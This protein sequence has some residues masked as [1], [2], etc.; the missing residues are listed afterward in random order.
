[1]ESKKKATVGL[2]LTVIMVLSVIATAISIV[3]SSPET[4][5]KVQALPKLQVSPGMMP[6]ENVGNET[7]SYDVPIMHVNLTADSANDIQI[8]VTGVTIQQVGN[9]PK[10]NLTNITVYLDEGTIGKFEPSAD[11]LL[12]F[13]NTAI[14]NATNPIN[15]SIALNLTEL[16][17]NPGDTKSIFVCVNYTSFPLSQ[18]LYFQ[19]KLW[20]VSSQD[21]IGGAVDV[22]L[23]PEPIVS[24]QIFATGTLKVEKGAFTAPNY[25][26][27]G[28]NETVVIMQVN[29]SAT[30][31]KSTL[32]SITL[33]WTGSNTSDVES[34]CLYNDTNKNGTLDANDACVTEWASFT[35]DEITLNFTSG[36]TVPVNDNVS[37]LIVVNTTKL[38]WSNDSLRVNIIDVDAVGDSSGKI[39]AI[40]QDTPLPIASDEIKGTAKVRVELGENQPIYKWIP[41]GDQ[42]N[43]E[44]VQLK[45]TAI[46]GKVNI[47]SLKLQMNKDNREIDGTTVSFNSDV[48]NATYP[49]V[50]MDVDGNGEIN[51]SDI[52]LN[53]TAGNL[54][55]DPSINPYGFV[56]VSLKPKNLT[57]GSET[58]TPEGEE[59]K[60]IIIAVNTSTN[61]DNQKIEI[62]I[63]WTGTEYNYTCYDVVTGQEGLH[64]D[65]QFTSNY[66][67]TTD[68]VDKDSVLIDIGPN[69]PSGAVDAGEGTFVGV[70]QLN[71]TNNMTGLKPSLELRGITVAANG[72]ANETIAISAL[73]L[74][75][76]KDMD[77]KYSAGDDVLLEPILSQP[78]KENDGNATITLTTPLEISAGATKTL[79]FFVNT[80]SN[81]ELTENL[82]FYIWNPSICFNITAMDGQVSVVN[83]TE[84]ALVGESLTAS[85]TVEAIFTGKPE[86]YNISSEANSTLIPLMQ[87][88]FSVGPTEPVN[89]TSITLNYTGSANNYSISK[90]IIVNDTDGDAQW[91]FETEAKLNEI[92]NPFVGNNN[93]TKLSF[94][95]NLTV[96]NVTGYGY[97]LVLVNINASAIDIGQ[98]VSVMISNP[99]VDYDASGVISGHGINDSRT[100]PIK[101][102]AL[103][104]TWTGKLSVTTIDIAN[105]TL[106]KGTYYEKELMKLQFSASDESINISSIRIQAN[107]SFNETKNITNVAAKVDGALRS[108]KVNF[109][110][111]DGYVVL[112][113]DPE[114]KIP[115]EKTRNVS[116][117]ADISGELSVGSEIVLRIE[118]PAR[119]IEAKGAV[120]KVKV[121][122]ET[123]TPL[124]SPQNVTITGSISVARGANTT[125]KGS[126]VAK[127]DS[128][129]EIL[130]LNFSAKY[131][132]VNITA[133]NLTWEGTFNCSP[134]NIT[135]GVVNDTD[136][137]GKIDSEEPVLNSTATFNTTTKVAS[138][139]L[140]P[141]NLT[142]PANGSAYMVIYLN[143]SGNFSP[144]ATLKVSLLN[145][146]ENCTAVGNVSGKPV[147]VEGV[148]IESETLTG[149]G[150]VVVQDTGKVGAKDILAGKNDSIVVWQFNITAELEN[151]TIES[152]TL[153]ENGTA[154]P[155]DFESVYL[156]NDTD[157]NGSWNKTT[158]P[159]ITDEQVPTTDNG[160]VTLTLTTPM[161]LNKSETVCYLVVVNT[162][163][164]FTDGETLAFNI[165]NATVEAKGEV[166][167]ISVYNN[168]TT[169][170]SNVTRGYGSI[171]LYAGDTQ[172]DIVQSKTG[173]VSVMELNFSAIRGAIDIMNITVRWIGNASTSKLSHISIWKDAD[174]D[175]NFSESDT[176]INIMPFDDEENIT[177]ETNTGGGS[178]R[179]LTVDGAT[180]NVY[181]V[182]RITDGLT[183]GKTLGF[184]V[185]QTLGVGYNAT[186]NKTRLTPYATMNATAPG[187]EITQSISVKEVGALQLKTGWNLVSVPKELSDDYDTAEELFNLQTGEPVFYYNASTKTYEP[188]DPN[189]TIEL[190][191]GYW[192]YKKT[193]YSVTPEFK[194]YGS[195][196]VPPI[197]EIHLEAGWNLIGHLDTK[198]VNVSTALGSLIDNGYAKYSK[199]LW[200]NTS[201]S[202]RKWD[203]C[204]VDYHGEPKPDA[205]FTRLEPYKGYFIYMRES[206]TYA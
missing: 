103:T 135:I 116:I 79:L 2:A 145:P 170:S 122:N 139:N 110:K 198:P 8:K 90:I 195:G 203:V 182:V 37:Y 21:M 36:Q 64:N 4:D 15:T 69:P 34:I 53:T 9:I 164:N 83:K 99:K 74:I 125:A 186:C 173:N 71:I 72:T 205:D 5:Y 38:F 168:F 130:Q 117:V 33:K 88:K 62:E 68:A 150:Y 178:I 193:D 60:Y 140:T 48:A 147:T 54:S 161:S 121:Q 73:G 58:E 49:K 177:I 146:A 59:S 17:L 124:Y 171:D 84:R 43:M 196:E 127:A 55:R 131:E 57:I 82:R 172:P 108:S 128:Y 112:E 52:P 202:P 75:E 126:V 132:D 142:V 91:D 3:S 169:Q 18:G 102:N 94:T 136:G 188:I 81:F 20:D 149:T 167:N 183:A 35:D 26:G 201:T 179:N 159:I 93:R 115:A 163:E 141:T 160:T 41:M 97:L 114:L 185:N 56:E 148:D 123:T 156:V 143:V 204:Y 92:T 87:V 189:D 191:K 24:K 19:M 27:A 190:G 63:N 101:S 23:Q 96:S 157:M 109:T 80:T 118:N 133:I 12:G 129:I 137:D 154:A 176:L 31:E 197:V 107:S 165:T 40:S 180:N 120:T 77:G 66:V 187:A 16:A 152:I 14:G 28:E 42:I 78:F 206:G 13:N 11:I 144:G 22:T 70:L 100:E 85:G 51:P 134:N 46:A 200:W 89:I 166:S 155:T 50:W 151:V 39:V 138:I 104:A 25:I 105:S 111:D 175:G 162:T 95:R 7:P 181:I 106:V 98:N 113:L 158:E 30:I 10:D 192:V 44:I 45:F 67:A 184:A 119:D 29:F 32:Q 174:G 65:T 1:M 194:T 6:T 86:A 61:A 47:T 153:Y 76:D 199:I